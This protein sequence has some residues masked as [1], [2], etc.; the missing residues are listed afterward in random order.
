MKD[1]KATHKVVDENGDLAWDES[2]ALVMEVRGTFCT[3]DV[4]E[5]GG[6]YYTHKEAT[7]EGYEI[8]PI[9]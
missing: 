5:E 3:K 6:R 2:D 7:V 8:I 1:F 9:A 4:W